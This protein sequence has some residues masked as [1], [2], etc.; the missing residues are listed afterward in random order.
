[1]SWFKIIIN[2]ISSRA[3]VQ[4]NVMIESIGERINGTKFAEIVQF[5]RHSLAAFRH[6]RALLFH[7]RLISLQISF[8]LVRRSINR[9]RYWRP[10]NGRNSRMNE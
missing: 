4:V 5:S 7:Y 6:A 3:N 8:D 10:S 2:S 9:R 1:V